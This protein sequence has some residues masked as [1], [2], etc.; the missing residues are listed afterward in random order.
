MASYLQV[1]NL[2]KSIGDR[3]LFA[4]ITFGVNE[5]DKIG[6]IAKNGMGK[7][8]LLRCI[9]GMDDYDSGSITFRSDIKVSILEQTPALDNELTVLQTCIADSG[10]IVAAIT[11]YEQA[12]ADGN[13]EAITLATEQMDASQAWDYEDRLKQMLSQL[14][15]HNL[16]QKVSQ[17]SGGQKKR[18]AIAK[19]ILENPDI[20]LLDEPTN[21]LDIDSI[22][23]L[24]S[25]LTRSRM[26]I[27]MVTHDR[28]FLD[29]VCDKIMEI[30]HEQMFCYE[31][32]YNNYL[33]RRQ[34]RIEAMTSE[35]AK[36]KNT[37]RREQEW[38]NRQPQARAG[39][40]KFRI[41]AFYDL[42]KRAAVDLRERNVNLQVKSSYIGSKIFEASHI[43]KRFGDKIIL[44]DF[45]YIF[46]R[47]EKLGIIGTNGVGKSTFVKMLQGLVPS[48]SGHWDIGETVKFGYYSQ[49]GIAFNPNKKVIDAITEIA[50]D[51]VINDGAQRFSPS[52]FLQHFLFTPADQQKLIAKLS[53]GERSRLHLASVLMK[54]PNFLILD[55]P[56]ND[57]DIVTLGILEEYLADFK[58]CCII[59][60]HDR[61]F[62]DNIVDHLFVLEG[63]GVVKDFPG[64]YTEYRQWHLEQEEMAR[65]Q[66]QAE[67]AAKAPK[68]QASAPQRNANKLTFK[69]RKELEALEADIA[70]LT[71]EKEALEAAF[72]SGDVADIESKSQR[73]DTVKS[74]L[75]EKEFRWLELSEKQ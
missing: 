13:I 26:T 1:E 17:L 57:L 4:D 14:G 34:E 67:E 19:I 3:M 53:G 47:Y 15:I 16:T 2:T 52:Q 31:G 8:T 30:D 75:D 51:I 45:N 48:D 22:E 39:K 33:R 5:G 20:I 6:I 28:Y 54:S 42:K 74:L 73:Y 66:K 24:E 44:D 72:A 9:A 37:L 62:L 49:D 7:T 64:N 18:V 55:E 68:T 70:T 59:I 61:Y 23:W 50:E 41:D 27:L 65:Q 63:N 58:G 21:H 29:R 36:V 11:A 71:E 25:Y 43:C 46:S 60:S 38:M 32:N 40:A 69:E 35:L 12:L 56:T 10:P